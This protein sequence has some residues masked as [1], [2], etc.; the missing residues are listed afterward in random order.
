MIRIF[1][2]FAFA[3]VGILLQGLLRM[4][5]AEGIVVLTLPI[6]LLYKLLGNRPHFLIYFVFVAIFA[7]AL[8]GIHGYIIVPIQY[9]YSVWGWPGVIAGII[10]TLLLPLQIVLFLGVALIKGGGAEYIAKFFGGLCFALSA[11]FV[12]HGAF[13]VS[14]WSKL[15]NWRKRDSAA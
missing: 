10:A 5:I 11:A 6:V 1:V 8:A 7:G 14:P 13:S 15:A 2:A 3:V 4:S 9:Y 12:A